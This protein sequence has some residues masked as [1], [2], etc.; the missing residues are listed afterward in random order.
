[1]SLKEKKIGKKVWMFPDAYLPAKGAQYPNSSKSKVYGHE[2]LCIINPNSVK[3][4]LKINFYFE[5]EKPIK[6]FNKTVDS[7]RSLHLR[8][9]KIKIPN[10]GY[11]PREKPYSIIV[12]SDKNVVKQLSRVDTTSKYNS[13]MSVLGWGD[14]V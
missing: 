9:D 5:K 1:M 6:N 8:L 3:A 10:H 7:E 12:K 2:S 4:K 14:D 13:F 11:L